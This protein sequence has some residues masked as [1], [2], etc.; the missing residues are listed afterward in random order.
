MNHADLAPILERQMLLQLGERLKR[1]RKSQGIGTVEMAARASISRMTLS[2]VESGDPGTAIGTYLRVLSL[3]GSGADFALLAADVVQQAPSS[4]TRTRKP[5]PSVRVI[6]STDDSRHQSQDLQSL[7]LHD[8]AV[9]LVQ[10]D[11]AL[12]QQAQDTLQRWLDA[13]KSPQSAELWR[14][15]Q[16]ILSERKW[17]A[18]LGRTRR[19]QELRQASPLTP[20]LPQDQRLQIIAQINALKKGLV[21][22]GNEEEPPHESR[23]S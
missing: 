7:A 18:V 6:V 5:A 3:L 12:L 22:G 19:A 20:L 23:R 14:E 1:L 13:G 11:S 15:W 2:A 4:A 8:A 17:R 9:K 21:L 10:N 16:Q